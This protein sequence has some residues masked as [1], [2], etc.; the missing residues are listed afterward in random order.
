MEN[1]KALLVVSFG[2]SYAETRAKTIDKLE[3]ALAAALPERRFYRAWTSK[4][5]IAKVNRRDG[6]QIPTVAEALRQ[7]QAD[8][9]TDL[10]VQPTHIL[11]GKENDLMLAEIRAQLAGFERV[12]VGQPL[13]TSGE[14]MFKTI[15]IVAEELDNVPDVALVLM[16]HG[17]GHQVNT[18]YAALDYMFKDRGHCNI[19]VGTVE[20]YP[21]LDNVISLLSKTPYSR[22][23]LAPFMIVA[24][25]HANNDMAGDGPDSW[26]NR[27]LEAGYTVE[28][29]LRGLG[30]S[31]QIAQL[32]CA[33]ALAAERIK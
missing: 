19:F 32:F 13:L 3:A 27:L 33:H 8:G 26:K 25:D 20:A 30:E 17:T 31:E 14:D 7:M 24:G 22:V 29:T 18:S 10:L 15:D 21:G 6:L 4:M 2:T 9:V 23:R 12:A 11:P 5:I 28:C 16:G 1:K